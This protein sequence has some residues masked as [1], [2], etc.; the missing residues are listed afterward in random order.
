MVRFGLSLLA[1]SLIA[2]FGYSALGATSH[3]YASP[4]LKVIAVVVAHAGHHSSV[5]TL[6]SQVNQTVVQ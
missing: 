6:R 2:F 5:S 4:G 1:A 3:T